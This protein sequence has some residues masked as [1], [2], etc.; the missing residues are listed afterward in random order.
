MCLALAGAG[1]CGSGGGGDGDDDIGTDGGTGGD[2]GGFNVADDVLSISDGCLGVYNPEQVLDLRFTM[3]AADWAALKADT[4]NSVLFPARF[5]CND[6]PALPYDIGIRRKRSGGTDKPGLKVDFNFVI[7]DGNFFSLKKL[8]LENGI[9]EG[10]GTADA[11]DLVSEY[12]AWRMMV[13]SGAH[14]SRA[15]F[16]RVHVNGTLIGAYVSVEQV[17]KRFLANRLGENDGW[18]YKKSGSADDGYKTNETQANPYEGDMCFWSGRG[19]SAPTELETYLPM[20]LDLDQMLRFGGVNAIIG[21][22][23]SPLGKDNNY[24]WYD[25]AAP[26]VYF[27]WDLDTTMREGTTIF[28]AGMTDMYTSVLFTHWEDDYDALLTGLLDD[29]LALP[30]IEGELDRVERVAGA[31]LDSDPTVTGGAG[32]AVGDLSSFWASRHPTLK[33]ELA[34]HAP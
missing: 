2:G 11:K 9:S 24:Y 7:P 12:L 15:V 1:A 29:E 31:A 25:S 28:G 33:A 23:D 10:S 20:H 5:Q 8:S 17:D 30:V 4:T 21:N 34:A 16:V 22:S 18:L 32:S 26:R 14:A 3:A 6:E 27:A 19:C 13:L